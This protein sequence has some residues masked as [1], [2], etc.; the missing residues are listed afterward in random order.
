M[1]SKVLD[2]LD[3]NT[4]R[5][6][7]FADPSAAQ[8]LATKHYVD[9]TPGFAARATAA[10]ATS[11]LAAGATDSTTTITLAK[12][13]RLY[14]IQTSRPA[15]VR[16]YETAAQLTA[17]LARAVGTDPAGDAGVVLEF[18]STD[19]AVHTLSPLVDGANLEA[20]PS[21]AISMAVTNN[22]TVTGTVTVTLVWIKAE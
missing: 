5:A 1:A 18:V 11:S 12:A 3:G 6:V 10:Q 9:T 22:D 13:Y 14:S 7:N 2:S 16:L 15:R 21:T 20:V 4:Q 8:D 17:D 19:T